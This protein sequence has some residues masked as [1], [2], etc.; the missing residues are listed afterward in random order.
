[1][2]VAHATAW[3]YTPRDQPYLLPRTVGMETLIRATDV[4][5][6]P[7][8]ARVKA[9]EDGDWIDLRARLAWKERVDEWTLAAWET[10]PLGA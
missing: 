4:Q 9:I 7:Q 2:Q 5:R 6:L 10:A 1:M 3:A 8:S